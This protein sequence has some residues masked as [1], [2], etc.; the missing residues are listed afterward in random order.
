MAAPPRLGLLCSLAGVDGGWGRRPCHQGLVV[1]T[2]SY[3][4]LNTWK[5]DNG[6]RKLL[7]L[8]SSGH[9]HAAKVIRQD[10]ANAGGVCKDVWKEAFRREVQGHFPCDEI[11]TISLGTQVLDHVES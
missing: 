8:V 9:H 11:R 10:V 2:I 6:I 3:W 5:A 4:K 7:V 1:R